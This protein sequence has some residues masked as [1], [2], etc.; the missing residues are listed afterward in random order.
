MASAASPDLPA[1]PKGYC[2]A[3]FG[4]LRKRFVEDSKQESPLELSLRATLEKFNPAFTI[5]S[6]AE[7]HAEVQPGPDIEWNPSLETYLLRVRRLA[8]LRE[9]LPTA[10]PAGFPN[11]ISSP[12]VWTGSDFEDEKSYIIALSPDEVGEIEYA[13]CYF[14]SLYCGLLLG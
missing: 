13:L 6:H 10:V 14:K 3:G 1:Q 11:S 7:V 5:D 9:T 4:G 12:R 2:A 8:K